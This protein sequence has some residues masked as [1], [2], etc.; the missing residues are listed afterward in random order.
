MTEFSDEL[1]LVINPAAYQWLIRQRG[2]LS[3]LL[4]N[5]DAWCNAFVIDQLRT[6]HQIGF[7]PA[8]MLD[9]GSGLGAIDVLMAK[10]G[11]HCTM[12]DA[13]DGTGEMKRHNIPFCNAQAVQTFMEENNVPRALYQY[14]DPRELDTA[15]HQPRVY[16]CVISL[17]SWCFHY[18]PD[19]YLPYVNRHACPGARIVLDVRKDVTGWRQQ[20]K[21]NWEE[22]EVL[23]EGEKYIRIEY[24]VRGRVQ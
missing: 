11:T 24:R 3:P 23:E 17:R 19:V 14:S 9:I 6:M 22:M 16:D 12:I 18:S 15:L 10:Q 13:V 7:V 1:S 8:H 21:A 4:G 20:L 5:R 2:E